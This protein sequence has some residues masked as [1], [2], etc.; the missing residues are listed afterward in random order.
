MK[1]SMKFLSF[2]ILVLLSEMSYSQTTNTVVIAKIEVEQSEQNIKITGTA[3]NLS[4]IVQSLSYKLSVIKKNKSN[5]NLSNNIQEGLF[6]L[7]PSENK[8]L[9]TSTVNLGTEDEVIVLLL[10]YNENKQLIGKDRVVLGDEKK[11]IK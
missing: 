7:N 1:T 11:K 5:N 9:S 4:D 6:S 3:E 8:N 10:F 2:L